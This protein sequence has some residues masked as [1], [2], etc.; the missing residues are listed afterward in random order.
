MDLDLYNL[1][2][3]QYNYQDAQQASLSANLYNLL[4]YQYNY[5]R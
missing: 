1:L 4:K 2:K 5:P 3:Y